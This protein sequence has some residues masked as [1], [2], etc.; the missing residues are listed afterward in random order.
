M[1]RLRILLP[2][3]TAILLS[4]CG[5]QVSGPAAAPSNDGITLKSASK[6]RLTGAF[7]D[8]A[9]N[10][11]AFDSARVSDTLFFDL[12]G[13]GGRS[14][15]HVETVGDNYEFSYMDGALK[16]HTTKAFVAQARAQAQAQPQ[17]V[18]TAGFVFDG[19]THVLD[20]MLQL[21]EIAS[22]PALSRA[23]GARGFNGSDFPATLA[24]HKS[25]R[26]TAEAL[27]IKVAQLPA[28]ASSNSYCEAYPNSWDSCYGMCGPGCSC[29]SWVCGDCCYHY[30]CAVHDSWCRNGD[31][32]WCYNITAVIALFGC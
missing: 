25:A 17:N 18:S 23:L 20:A 11:L 16:M 8:E 13:N 19:D 29:W 5:G 12:R 6:E 2:L 26:Q 4:A 10:T 21:P 9:G 22:L 3:S 15:I 31:W 1:R 14:I 7:M 30:G 24:L 32:W 28:S 27:G